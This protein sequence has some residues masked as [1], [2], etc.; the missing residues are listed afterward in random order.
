M[1]ASRRLYL[2]PP[3][4]GADERRLL[5]EAFDSNW[6][7]PLGPHVDAFQEEF[8]SYVGVPRA[9]ALSSGT[10]ALHLALLVS[11]VAAGDDVLVSTLT[12]AGSVN[13]IRYVGANPVF[14][15]SESRTWNLDPQLLEDYL[16][17]AAKR[18][19]MPRA[20][21]P[22]HLYGQVAEMAPI[23][24]L[25]ERYGIPVIEDAAEALGATYGG[26]AA[27]T[28]GAM[29]IYSFNGNKV[30]TT[31]GGGMVVAE[32]GALLDRVL[33]LATQAREPAAHYEHQ[34][35][36]FNYRLSNLLAAVGR[37]QLGVLDD[38]LRARA[39]VYERYA[40]ALAGL[41]GV[42][43]QPDTGPG[44]HSRWLTT[45]TVDPDRFGA[46]ATEVRLALE[47]LNIEARPL[48]KPMHMQPVYAGATAVLSGVSEALYARGIC[49]PSGSAMSEADQQ[50]VIDVIAGMARG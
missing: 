43:F 11:G 26:R 24:G 27:G 45:A 20:I 38:R 22:V 5:L 17:K 35:I 21:V 31:S 40:T 32:D 29:G 1:T 34:E 7:A 41:P 12:F 9:V 48:W 19:R 14:V 10:A 49:L 46:T 6:I 8:A 15:D 44:S 16:A 36:G 25:G 30:I 42:T 23:L 3:H 13:P 37:G 50:R 33:K 18:G 2:S 4:M 39:R 28:L 47:A